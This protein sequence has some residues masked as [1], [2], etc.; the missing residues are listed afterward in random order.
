MKTL[1]IASKDKNP[2]CF[3]GYYSIISGL[4]ATSTDYFDRGYPDKIKK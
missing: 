4:V 3:I 2:D 1:S